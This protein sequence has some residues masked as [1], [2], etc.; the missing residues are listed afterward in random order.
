VAVA[1]TRHS[2]KSCR[3]HAEVDEPE[4]EDQDKENRKAEGI[5]TIPDSATKAKTR[6]SMK[7]KGS[8]PSEISI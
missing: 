7:S 3:I 6:A 4:S 1:Y 5:Y 8:T 2:D